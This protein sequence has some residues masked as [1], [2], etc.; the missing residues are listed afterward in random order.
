MKMNADRK[1]SV[2]MQKIAKQL[3]EHLESIA[4]E[5]MG[6]SLVVFN[7][8]ENSRMNYVSNC[9]RR[10]VQSALKDLL[11]GWEKGMP[12]IPAHEVEG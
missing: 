9:D 7:V 3:E 10:E 12:D 11:E 4:G 6:F 5:R 2:A 8:V 1:I